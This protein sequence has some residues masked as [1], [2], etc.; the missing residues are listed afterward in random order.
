MRIAVFGAGLVGRRVATR[1]AASKLGDVVLISQTR[2]VPPCDGVTI[3]QGWPHP[4]AEQA[5][6]VV[7][8]VE[9]AHQPAMAMQLL[10][11][12]THV[13]STADNPADIER[14]WGFD[15][16]ATEAGATLIVGAGASPGISTLLANYLARTM[17]TVDTIS[18][19]QFGTGGPACAREH[20]R[21]MGIAAHEVHQGALRTSRG[22]TGRE[23]VWFPDPIGAADC[24]R[25]GLAD[26][27]LLHQA[28]PSVR[29][30]E[31]RQAATRRD[32][33]TARLPMLR[34]PHAEGLIGAVWAEVRGHRHGRAEH[35]AMAATAPQATGAAAMVTAFCHELAAKNAGAPTYGVGAQSAATTEN[36]VPLIQHISNDV[37][38]WTYD[39]SQILMK[40]AEKAPIHAAR[41]WRIP[42]EN[43]GI[44][45]IS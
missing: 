15:T 3:G 18:T 2:A 6:I 16:L 14:L 19:A 43:G 41:K 22:G 38:L 33:L 4:A 20:H 37:R 24:Y 27:F 29:R 36:V 8:A 17:D 10:R 9:S 39:G 1:L 31:S 28:F 11:A 34:P 44:S 12:G 13:V 40:S 30:I 25:G 5:H 23:L 42:G 35:R 32:R 21:A 26:P 7:L 45:T